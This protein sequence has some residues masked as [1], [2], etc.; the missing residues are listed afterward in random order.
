VL[1]DV[2][3]PG[4][5]PL[6]A[7]Q[8][9]PTG[10]LPV[11]SWPIT[12]NAWS[13]V[14]R[15]LFEEAIDNFLI[16][17]S[18]YLERVLLEERV[19]ELYEKSDGSSLP[20]SVEFDLMR[21]RSELMSDE[22]LVDPKH[23][24]TH[25]GFKHKRWYWSWWS[26]VAWVATGAVCIGWAGRFPARWFNIGAGS[27]WVEHVLSMFGLILVLTYLVLRDTLRYAKLRIFKFA[28]TEE[29]G[30][31]GVVLFLIGALLDPSL[32]PRPIF[33]RV[34]RLLIPAVTLLGVITGAALTSRPNGYAFGYGTGAA[35]GLACYL[36]TRYR[37]PAVVVHRRK[38]P[39]PHN[40]AVKRKG[41]RWTTST[42]RENYPE[43]QRG[44]IGSSRSPHP[45]LIKGHYGG[46]SI[47]VWMV[48]RAF[49]DVVWI[50]VAAVIV[51]T[52]PLVLGLHPLLFILFAL[53]VEC[54]LVHLVGFLPLMYQG[55]KAGSSLWT[56]WRTYQSRILRRAFLLS[57][58]I[59]SLLMLVGKLQEFIGFG[60]RVDAALSL[61]VLLGFPFGVRVYYQVI[62]TS[63]SYLP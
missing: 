53:W 15:S 2:D 19:A 54:F 61:A 22:W 11:R 30:E 38:P 4:T 13:N 57:F 29:Y 51:A 48:L 52:V 35:I 55:W 6:M 18:W 10:Q 27:A 25:F 36:L 24:L 34:I 41:L 9:L 42:P 47:S 37:A 60:K 20:L 16:T 3:L 31:G 32:K 33:R 8:G 58:S 7:V 59:I 28:R 40:I 62:M 46:W 39:S 56:E 44:R 43:T 5:A 17:L 14:S 50:F 49:I 1:V 26:V 63:H 23:D 45:P 12:A 21:Y